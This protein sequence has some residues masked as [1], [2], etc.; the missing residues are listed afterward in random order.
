[1]NS[2]KTLFPR[3]HLGVGVCK[4]QLSGSEW[5]SVGLDRGSYQTCEW[6]RGSHLPYS[7]ELGV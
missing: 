7:L 2:R 4:A 3:V 1:M 6:V 5:L